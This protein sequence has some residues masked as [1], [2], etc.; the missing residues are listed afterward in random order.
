[1]ATAV[2]C[3][4]HF[5]VTVWVYSRSSVFFPQTLQ[6]NRDFPGMSRLTCDQTSGW[7]Y[8]RC[9][10]G[11]AQLLHDHAND[12]CHVLYLC[13]AHIAPHSLFGQSPHNSVWSS[14]DTASSLAAASHV[15]LECTLCLLFYCTETSPIATVM[16]GWVEISDTSGCKLLVWRL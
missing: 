6:L 14:M 4:T 10:L 16:V 5:T 2:Q 11:L 3:W 7:P 1:M 8:L 13:P 12:F 15:S 9:P